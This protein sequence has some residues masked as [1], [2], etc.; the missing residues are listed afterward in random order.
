MA[1][2]DPKTYPLCSYF[3]SGHLSKGPDPLNFPPTRFPEALDN[4]EQ[5][6]ACALHDL[7]LTKEALKSRPEFD[8]DSGNPANLESGIG[9]LRIV[10]ALRLAAFHNIA[11]VRPAKN[12][13]SADI[14]CEQNGVRVCLEVKTVTKQSC[15]RTGVFL[16][17]QL[18]EKMLES[19]SKARAQL[20]ATAAEL[21][22]PVKIFA[23]AVNWFD[24]S[25]F[26]SRDDYHHI[27][28][29][30]E[31]DRDE[32]RLKGV[33]GVLLVIESGER[34]WFLKDSGKCIDTV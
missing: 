15:G 8:F 6:F 1:F 23:C 19:I 25:I 22:C 2:A 10:R 28:S 7:G 29:R 13:P 14:T 32:K 30:L 24:Q 27:V 18:Y 20:D 4:Y 34:L 21:Q 11:L 17:E 12:A 9:T 5:T 26:L 31:R 16:E 33:D 3:L